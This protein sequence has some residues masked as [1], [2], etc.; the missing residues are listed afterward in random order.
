MTLP[1]H[2]CFCPLLIPQP[3]SPLECLILS[4]TD[5]QAVNQ[6]DWT[7]VLCLKESRSR[8]HVN[9]TENYFLS[10]R[11]SK[12]T[13]RVLAIA[14]S[15]VCQRATNALDNCKNAGT[16]RN[17]IVMTASCFFDPGRLSEFLMDG[18]RSD[19]CTRMWTPSNPHPRLRPHSRFQTVLL[20]NPATPAR[21]ADY[22][23]RTVTAQNGNSARQRMCYA[24]VRTPV[25]FS[26]WHKRTGNSAVDGNKT[27][28]LPCIPHIHA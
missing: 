26:P 10:Q 15:K 12:I 17:S 13:G 19:L 27:Y 28:A 9:Y 21:D 16:R 22:P 25:H 2:F 4:I 6:I 14:I 11:A 5:I 20:S 8:R 3:A 7:L 1:T 18:A 23:K 24:V